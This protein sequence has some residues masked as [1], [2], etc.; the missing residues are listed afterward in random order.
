MSFNKIPHQANSIQEDNFWIYILVKPS[1]EKKQDHFWSG[2]VDSSFAR[3]LMS[4]KMD[5]RIKNSKNI[6]WALPMGQA[7]CCASL[8]D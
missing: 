4:S 3:L 5:V 7:L 2:A 6:Y 8:K 1:T